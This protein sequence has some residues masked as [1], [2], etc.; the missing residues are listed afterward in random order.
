MANVTIVDERT[1]KIQV[2]IEDAVSMIQKKPP[3]H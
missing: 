1:I 2:S 3:W